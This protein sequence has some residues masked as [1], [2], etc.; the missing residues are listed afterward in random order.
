M[1]IAS[2]VLF[3]LFA[4]KFT[5]AFQIPTQRCRN[6]HTDLFSTVMSVERTAQREVGQFI[7]WAAQS[8]IQ[9]AEGFCLMDYVMDENEEYY[10]A[11]STGGSQGSSVLYVPGELILS[12][13]RIAQET[14]GYADDALKLLQNNGM[15]HLSQQFLLFLQVLLIYQQGDQSPHFPWMSA[16]PRKW[17]TA[18]SMD[19]FCMSC[20]PPYIKSLC[21]EK[22]DQLDAFHLALQEFQH[23]S[24]EI[25]GNDDLM[26]FAYN[27]VFTRSFPS[28]SDGD[29]KLI[30]MVDMINHGY[31]GNVELAYDENGGCGVVLA[32]DVAPGEPLLLSYGEPSNPS[33]LLATY[34]FL[35]ESASTTNCKLMFKNP[36]QELIDVGYDPSRMLFE[37]ATGAVSQEVWDVL[38][39]SRLEKKP[40][41]ADAAR[42]FHQASISGDNQTKN[43]IHGQYFRHTC[44]ALMRHIDHILIEVHDLTVKMNAY[45]SSKHPRLPLLRRHHEMVTS[46]FKKVKA[47]VEQMMTQQ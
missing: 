38:L 6:V 20:L 16:L 8:G 32:R 11:T 31:P 35:S 21:Q 17:N 24:P 45:D 2:R 12:A 13:S 25:K 3:G 19:K 29:L 33:R 14:Q 36:S 40:E 15:I 41:L 37:T 34:G 5:G 46:T 1:G 22:R 27:V 18:V 7:N 28:A 43:A 39:Y 47:N 10:A 9:Q 30:P 23:I 42:A 26:K 44:G 4:V